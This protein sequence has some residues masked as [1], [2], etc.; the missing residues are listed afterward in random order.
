MVRHRGPVSLA[1]R[2]AEAVTVSAAMK[3]TVRRFLRKLPAGGRAGSPIYLKR[4]SNLDQ[5][6]LPMGPRRTRTGKPQPT[7]AIP[8]VDIVKPRPEATRHVTPI[9]SDR[10][11]NGPIPVVWP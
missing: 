4:Q 7:G 1:L 10:Q 11:V 5:V 6:R 8:E 9:S 3:P 2:A